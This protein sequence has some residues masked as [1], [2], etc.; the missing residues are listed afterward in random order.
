MNLF[1][2]A[3]GIIAGTVFGVFV[4]Y[5]YPGPVAKLIVKAMKLFD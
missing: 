2:L 4:S 5:R 3:L 1:F